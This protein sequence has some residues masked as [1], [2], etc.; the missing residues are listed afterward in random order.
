MHNQ[1][2]ISKWWPI[3]LGITLIVLFAVGGGLISNSAYTDGYF[4]YINT[5]MYYG[6]IAACVLGGCVSIA[7][8]VMIIL[9]FTR[10][11]RSA[12]NIENGYNNVNYA[13][14]HTTAPY[15]QTAMAKP[16]SIAMTNQMP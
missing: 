11:N 2:P 1:Q 8:I 6:G 14:P 15:Q 4:I 3:G 12:C 7:F 9:Y 13:Q 5:G 10:R 16:E